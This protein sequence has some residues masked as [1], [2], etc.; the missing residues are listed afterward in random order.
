[1]VFLQRHS[2]LGSHIS[3]RSE[4]PGSAGVAGWAPNPALKH[5]KILLAPS[6]G[7][8][9][10]S[11]SWLERLSF[12]IRSRPKRLPRKGV[13]SSLATFSNSVWSQVLTAMDS[14]CPPP[15]RPS[16]R[17]H[18]RR[19]TAS[20]SQVEAVVSFKVALHKSSSMLLCYEGFLR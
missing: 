10:G 9:T 16:P 4:V 5:P 17:P 11:F 19:E 3:L 6:H 1:M 7:Q 14:C 2:S 12:L 20:G 8:L 15:P 18:Q 13:S